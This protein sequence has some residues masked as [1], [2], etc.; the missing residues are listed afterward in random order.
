M[1]LATNVFSAE[2]TFIQLKDARLL[3]NFL[4]YYVITQFHERLSHFFLLQ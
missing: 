4:L 1:V 3:H 2:Q